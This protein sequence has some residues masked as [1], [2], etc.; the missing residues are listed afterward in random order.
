MTTLPDLVMDF[1]AAETRAGGVR[2]EEEEKPIR[3]EENN[4]A[5]THKKQS[6]EIAVVLEWV[7]PVD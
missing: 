6:E 1:S 7:S 5:S 3:Y 2:A 4:V